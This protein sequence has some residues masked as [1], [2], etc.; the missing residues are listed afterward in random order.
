MKNTIIL[1][2]LFIFSISTLT[3]HGQYYVQCGH[4]VDT[5]NGT[6]HDK[7]TIIIEA[8][9]IL[10]VESGWS[11]VPQGYQLVDL[12]QYYLLPGLID[13]HVHIENETNPRRYVE[14]YVFEEADIAYKAQY[15]AKVTLQAGFTTVRDLGGTGV[16]VNL[17]NA[18]NS[19]LVEGPR[20]FT[21]RKSIA[22]TGGHADPTNGAKVD[23]FGVP[24]PEHGVADGPEACIQAVRHQ[25]KYGADLI[26]ITA[27]GGVLSEAKDG[28]RP[29]FSME[30][31]EAI[32]NTAQDRGV[33]VAAHAHGD[34]GMYR[35]VKAGV[36]TIEHGTLMSE[37]TM[38]LMIEKNAF[39]VPTITAGKAVADS[40]EIPG[41][42]PEVVRP[43]ARYIGPKIQSTFAKAY[44]M[45]VPI[46][47]GTDAG[48]FQH[49]K[50]A[51]EF[52]YMTE[53]G[54]PPM[55]AIQSAT[56]T[57]ARLLGMEHKIGV[58]KT[59]AFADLIAVKENPVENISTLGEVVWVMK[60]GSIYKE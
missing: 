11:S 56:I 49:G 15:F 42:Y 13:M 45:G 39:L 27:T 28:F 16:N 10:R 6:I 32:V 34:E 30:E 18:I 59:G 58:I 20:I 1:Q 43:K 53:A 44:K 17:R 26:K 33:I 7:A 4:W 14:R 38:R 29:A 25:I 37:K 48:V 35:A 55:E 12:T 9:T 31:L 21:S 3:L 8:D 41:Y 23:L 22:I 50:N 54:M 60:N 40:A 51:L 47:F 2:V 5:Q 19:G 36:K 24:G 52:V 57:S 46:A